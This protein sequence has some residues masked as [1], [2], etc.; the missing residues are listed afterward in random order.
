MIG[1]TLDV[2]ELFR[3]LGSRSDLRVG[4]RIVRIIC[5]GVHSQV[6]FEPNNFNVTIIHHLPLI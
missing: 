5:A 2:M 4:D 1:K 3:G 6:I